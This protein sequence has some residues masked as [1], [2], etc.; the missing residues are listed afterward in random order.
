[1]SESKGIFVDLN[2]SVCEHSNQKKIGH[3][4]PECLNFMEHGKMGPKVATKNNGHY[5]WTC[6]K[7]VLRI[8]L[9]IM[10]EISSFKHKLGITVDTFFFNFFFF[11]AKLSTHWCDEFLGVTLLV[12]TFRHYLASYN[13][14]CFSFNNMWYLGA[15]YHVL[16]VGL[17]LEIKWWTGLTCFCHHQV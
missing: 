6:E 13:A 8:L 5:K 12:I 2:I 7:P 14:V 15:A 1:M 17:E 16:S 4:I 9:G 11:W 10:L 3:P